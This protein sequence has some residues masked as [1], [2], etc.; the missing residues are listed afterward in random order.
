[1]FKGWGVKVEKKYWVIYH[2]GVCFS[3]CTVVRNLN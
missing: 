3:A 1:V 2:G